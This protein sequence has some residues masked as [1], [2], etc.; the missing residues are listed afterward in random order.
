MMPIPATTI[1][2]FATLRARFPTWPELKAHLES[3]EGGGLRVVEGADTTSPVIIRYVKGK[4]SFDQFGATGMFRS[5]VWDTVANRPLCMAPP[6]AREGLPPAGLQLS[7]TQDFVDGFMVNVFIGPRGLTLATRT[8]FGGENTFYSEKSFGTMFSEALAASPLKSMEGL[9]AALKKDGWQFASF[10]VC[11]PEH[12]VVALT[13][14]PTLFCVHLGTVEENGT[15]TLAEN[16]TTWPAELARMQ[17]TAYPTRKF[18]SEKEIQD[19]LRKTAVQRGWRWQGL[20]FK[21]GT[22]ARWRVRTPTYTMLRELRGSE[23][24][25]VE[26]FLR[27]RR[28]GK[29][30]EYL[31]H[32]GED[33][34]AYWGYEQKLRD[35]TDALLRAYADCHKAHAVAFK[36]LPEGYRPAVFQLHAK[37]LQ[38][39]R[40]KGYKVRLQNAIGVVNGLR[41]FEQQRLLEADL[42]QAIAAA[43]TQPEAAEQPAAATPEQLEEQTVAE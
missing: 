41:A 20:V 6:K 35:A 2:H 15:V 34:K 33:R 39:L 17:V 37:W 8:Q 23:A 21:D 7:A 43:S 22:G 18:A 26:R 30:M 12:R 38:E 1:D 16:P 3:Q 27:L 5:V 19:L 24:S 4:S 11:H 28:E 25:D 13:K 10:V 31:K 14:S 32:Y 42:Y 40:A 9:E 36:D 29:V